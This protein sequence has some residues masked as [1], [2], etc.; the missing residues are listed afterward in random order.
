MLSKTTRNSRS[1]HRVI[2]YI[3]YIYLDAWCIT[4]CWGMSATSAGG[5]VR[6]HTAVD[7]TVSSCICLCHICSWFLPMSWTLDLSFCCLFVVRIYMFGWLCQATC[8]F[9]PT[10]MLG[11]SHA[12]QN[13]K[14]WKFTY[15]V[16]VLGLLV[17]ITYSSCMWTRQD[18]I[19]VFPSYY[20]LSA[21]T[22]VPLIVQYITTSLLM[23]ST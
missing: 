22:C 5:G 12:V 11:I 13:E 3:C 16:L 6:F 4:C 1:L 9:V 15:E 18:L 8:S 14:L 10:S 7:S 21:T 17:T 20:F 2:A 19:G 23:P